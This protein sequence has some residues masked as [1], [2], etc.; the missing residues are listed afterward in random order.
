[1]FGSR[2][3][4]WGL[5]R[6]YP[7]VLT[8]SFLSRRN[9]NAVILRISR[10][11]CFAVLLL[12]GLS[13]ASPVTQAFS[14]TGHRVVGQICHDHLSDKAKASI[15]AIMGLEK[16]PF[17]A[18]WPD[19]MR[20]S[21]NNKTFWSNASKWHFV[22]V[23]AK[24]SYVDAPKAP[25]GDTIVAIEAFT[26][27]L[28]GKPLPDG[29]VKSNLQLYFGDLAAEKNQLMIKQFAVR[30]LI[31]LIGDL[32]QP[33]HAGYKADR[34]GNNIKVKWF[35]EKQTLHAVWDGA[36]IDRQ[37]LSY[38]ELAVKLGTVSAKD[39]LYMQS[40]ELMD[41]LNES[42]ELRDIA[43]NVD[44][45]DSDFTAQYFF[46]NMPLIN[47]QLQKAGFRAAKIFNDIFK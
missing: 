43:Y 19:E 6:Y 32:H 38:T 27:L 11:K 22:N 26:A 37:K 45:Y 29:P 21:H 8:S 1:L 44:K 36:M 7:F 33:L 12:A 17:A 5:Y 23:P 16:L 46:D 9:I 4:Q 13:L 35:G 2:F 40:S 10:M 14:F 30:F 18:T 28:K 39:K 34:G 20:R 42:L 3:A 31:H 41:W 47:R 24:K 15:A 25:L